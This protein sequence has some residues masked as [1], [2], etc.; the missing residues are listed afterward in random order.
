MQKELAL[1]QEKQH[2]AKDLHQ[3]VSNIHLLCEL[4]LDTES[5]AIGEQ[6]KSHKMQKN[7]SDVKPLKN[8]IESQHLPSNDSIFDF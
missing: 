7:L 5:S 6:S 8:T 4:I 2:V 3:H 1:A